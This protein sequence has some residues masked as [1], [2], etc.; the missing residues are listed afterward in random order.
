MFVCIWSLACPVSF[1]LLDSYFPVQSGQTRETRKNWIEFKDRRERLLGVQTEPSSLSSS[2][3]SKYLEA[4]NATGK[5][6]GIIFF[7]GLTA[8]AA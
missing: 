4:R 5:Q 7:F 2:H 1:H 3:A 8:L 6:I